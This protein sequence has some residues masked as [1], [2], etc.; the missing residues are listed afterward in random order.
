MKIKQAVGVVCQPVW[1]RQTKQAALQ[2]GSHPCE[3]LLV[4]TDMI[5]RKVCLVVQTGAVGGCC[6]PK[7]PQ[8]RF[9]APRDCQATGCGLAYSGATNCYLGLATHQKCPLHV[10]MHDN[11]E[12]V[13]C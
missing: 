11:G 12:S 7:M 1:W 8:G 3:L 6:H 10:D 9:S 5:L 13:G 2:V 4:K